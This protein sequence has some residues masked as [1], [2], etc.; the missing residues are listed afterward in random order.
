MDEQWYLE[1]HRSVGMGLGI[2]NADQLENEAM[3]MAVKLSNGPQ[4]AMQ[5]LKMAVYSAS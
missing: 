4:M 1:R 5:L 2:V 3:Q